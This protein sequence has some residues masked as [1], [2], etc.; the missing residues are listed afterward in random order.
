MKEQTKKKA[1]KARRR[2]RDAGGADGAAYRT[3]MGPTDGET[4]L[5]MMNPGMVRVAAIAADSRAAQKD[6]DDRAEFE[7]KAIAPAVNTALETWKTSAPNA[8]VMSAQATFGGFLSQFTAWAISVRPDLLSPSAIGSG[9]SFG[10]TFEPSTHAAA[11][12]AAELLRPAYASPQGTPPT[13]DEDAAPTPLPGG[14]G[15]TH[16]RLEEAHLS[17]TW[18]RHAATAVATLRA[19]FHEV[20]KVPDGGIAPLAVDE[21]DPTM[22]REIAEYV[23]AQTAVLELARQCA[24]TLG[25]GSTAYRSLH[26]DST[27]R[28]LYRAIRKSP[29]AADSR[30]ALQRMYGLF[31]VGDM[32]L[33]YLSSHHRPG[34]PTAAR[35]LHTCLKT[36]PLG[37]GTE[38]HLSGPMRTLTQKMAAAERAGC[39]RDP[40]HARL[41]V[42]ALSKTGSAMTRFTLNGTRTDWDAFALSHTEALN[43]LGGAEFPPAYFDKLVNT[44]EVAAEELAARAGA[45]ASVSPDSTSEAMQE[46]GIGESKRQRAQATGEGR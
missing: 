28:T 17:A 6:D 38:L 23:E 10:D 24:R 20:A 15:P 39:K 31:P 25:E 34:V 9:G 4:T 21:L 45:F 30:C 32:A 13:R 22:L 44:L 42:T 46:R 7:E 1:Q 11:T 2:D 33:L 5:P 8:P 18:R 29:P 36:L 26:A 12:V 19:T 27:D 37:I 16:R 3:P 35:D 41:L 43:A 14:I 40:R